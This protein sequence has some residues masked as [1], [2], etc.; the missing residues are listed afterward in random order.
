[1]LILFVPVL[2]FYLVS[3]CSYNYFVSYIFI[4]LIVKERVSPFQNLSC[5][6]VVIGIFVFVGD[7]VIE[8]KLRQDTQET[9]AD[10]VGNK[11]IP[12]EFEPDVV[13]VEVNNA[14]CTDCF[15]AFV[16]ELIFK[17]FVRIQHG[18]TTYHHLMFH[19]IY[20]KS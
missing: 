8:R 11:S 20:H 15:V 14:S 3:L 4:M 9:D 2:L 12:I 7:G 1:M 6:L 19:L 13:P 16:D 17:C 5:S 10:S 18:N